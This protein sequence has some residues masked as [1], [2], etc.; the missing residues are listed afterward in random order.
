MNLAAASLL[1]VAYY[2]SAAGHRT[3]PPPA[4]LVR[5][6]LAPEAALVT[7]T[8]LVGPVFGPSAATPD[9]MPTRLAGRCA[10]EPAALVVHAEGVD[11]AT[12]PD[13]APV[14][15][16]RLTLV[17]ARDGKSGTARFSYFWQGQWRHCHHQS[18]ILVTE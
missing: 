9:R 3:V 14:P 10:W 17:L 4:F 5:L 12:T 2:I 11:P 1:Q 15:N 16:T 18:V 6:T 8:G 7:G 13:T